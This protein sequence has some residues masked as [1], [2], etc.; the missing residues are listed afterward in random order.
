MIN[1]Q[2]NKRG[3]CVRALGAMKFSETLPDDLH[4]ER[5]IKNGD[6]WYVA[7]PVTKKRN[8]TENQ[9]RLCLVCVPSRHSL[10][11]IIAGIWANK[12]SRG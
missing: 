12:T 1:D 6:K 7:L 10:A 9:G 2:K 3:F 8:L 5:I 11:T 4:D